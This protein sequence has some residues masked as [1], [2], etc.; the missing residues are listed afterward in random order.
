MT[1]QQRED[2]PADIEVG[3]AWRAGSGKIVKKRPAKIRTEGDDVETEELDEHD[4]SR[5]HGRLWRFR[6]WLR[7]AR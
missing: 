5:P 4:P 7:E 6:T 3:V 2:V 1:G